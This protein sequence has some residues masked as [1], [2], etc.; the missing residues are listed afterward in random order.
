MICRFHLGFRQR[1]LVLFRLFHPRKSVP[2]MPPEM[3]FEV[4]LLGVVLAAAWFFSTRR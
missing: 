2:Q 3:F 1:I 4:A